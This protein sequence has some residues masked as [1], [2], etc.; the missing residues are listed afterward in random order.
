MRHLL[1]RCSSAEPIVSAVFGDTSLHN[2]VHLED[3]VVVIGE[4]GHL[5]LSVINLS[6]N[7]QRMR[8]GT[9]QG[10]VV[11][12]ALVYPAIPQ[13][14]DKPKSP[15]TKAETE[16]CYVY[17]IY[18]NINLATDSELRSS[19]EFEFLSSTDPSDECLSEREKR[20]SRP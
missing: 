18:E 14:P 1:E 12:V 9:H 20:K 4:A 5:F 10:T 2:V 15:T 17:K 13:T 16:S 19:S 11:P 3:C 7:A 8:S 6:S